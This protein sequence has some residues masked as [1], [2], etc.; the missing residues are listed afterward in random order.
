MKKIIG[1]FFT[2]F[3]IILLSSCAKMPSV[4]LPSVSAPNTTNKTALRIYQTLPIYAKAAKI[5]W[6]PIQHNNIQLSS[7]VRER[8]IA[9]NIMHGDSLSAAIREFQAQNGLEQTGHVNQATLTALNITPTERYRELVES[10]NEWAKYPEDQNSR[11]IQVNIPSYSMTLISHGEEILQMKAIVGRPSRPT[12]LLTS[13]VTTIVFNPSW[14]VPETILAKDVIPGMR[15]NPNYMKEH[16]DM[17]IYASFDKNAP[18]VDASS[19]NWET[20]NVSNFR[21]RVTA[22][23]SDVNPLGR[24]KFIFEND[25]DVYMHDTPEKAVFAMHDR[26]RSSGCIRLENPL[27]LVQYFYADNTDLNA[28]LVNQYLSTYQTKYVQLRNPIPVYITYMTAWVDQEGRAHFAND[29]YQ[30]KSQPRS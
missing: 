7:I 16:Y 9:L 22:P 6:E 17:H 20:A 1:L 11:Y 28:E 26:A 12:P 29:I 21:Y 18:Q 13:K 23:P 4:S 14:T 30:A 3:V 5:P 15:E 24:F 25:H 2:G 19:I 10:M 8:L 27:A